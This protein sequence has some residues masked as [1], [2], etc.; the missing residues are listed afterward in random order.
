MGLAKNTGKTTTLN[1]MM[2]LY[3]H[4]KIGLTSI[5]L[6]GEEL[7]QIHFLPKPRIYVHPGM[8]VATAQACLE[9]TT[10]KYRVLK[11]VDLFTALGPIKMVE[12]LSP[13]F[14]V[15]AGP[16]TNTDLKHLLEIMNPYVDKLFVDGAFNRMTFSSLDQIDGIVLAT[17]AAVHPTMKKTI[18]RTKA[19]VESFQFKP[20]LVYM[21]LPHAK[22]V[23]HGASRV[24]L[25]HHKSYASFYEAIELYK[26]E[27]EMIYIQGAITPKMI[28]VFLEKKIKN[29]EMIIDDPTKLLISDV[30]FEYLKKLNIKISVI[31]QSK[32]LCVT[33]NPF[34][35]TGECYDENLF[36]NE[37]QKELN[38]PV[39]NVKKLEE[40]YVK[41]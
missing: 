25:F 33:I 39:F 12:V 20:S 37:L 32:L 26:H 5:G 10:I 30:Y 29:I 34:R 16:T 4:E 11:K 23:I 28:D 7:D 36:L 38:V 9:Q 18:S 22:L 13:G 19:I 14:L 8:V 17:G 21:H 35:P 41:T 24:H 40:I 2:S 27:M 31:H 3:E 15:V 1:Y 6:D